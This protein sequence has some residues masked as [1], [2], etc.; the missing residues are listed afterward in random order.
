MKIAICDD[1]PQDLHQLLDLVRRYDPQ[2]AIDAFSSA[3][4]LYLAAQSTRYDA[5]VLDIEM[6][7]PNGYEIAMRLAQED[8]HPIIVFATNSADYAVRGYGLALRYLLKPLT[9]KSV[10]EAM[11][12]VRK[13]ILGSRLFV[14]LDGTAHALHVQDVYYAE[15]SGHQSTLHTANGVFTSRESLRD[16]ADQLPS[17]Y[18][19]APHQSFLVNLLHVRTVDTDTLVLTNGIIIP[20]SRR[21]QKEFLMRFYQFLGV[22]P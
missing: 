17:R 16:L 6:E 18:F 13:E 11:D 5:V 15:V 2:A 20:C 14:T 8:T 19:C 22:Q 3:K 21:K 7:A 4:E 9:L 12:A 1:N 10:A